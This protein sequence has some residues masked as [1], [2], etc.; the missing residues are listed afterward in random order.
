MV[1]SLFFGLTMYPQGISMVVFK[2]KAKL[3]N[4]EVYIDAIYRLK[5][6]DRITVSNQNYKI[7]FFT[8]AKVFEMPPGMTAISYTEILGKMTKTVNK[9]F[10]AYIE[11]YHLI[12]EINNNANSGVV[13]GIEGLNNKKK[14]ALRELDQYALPQD[15]VRT[16]K[17]T[18]LLEWKL[19]TAVSQASLR[20]TNQATGSVVLEKKIGATGSESIATPTEGWYSWEIVSPLENKSLVENAW[21]RM[22]AAEAQ[23]EKTEFAGFKTSIRVFDPETQELLIEDYLDTHQLDID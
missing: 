23:K 17:S 12:N 1:F 11:K 6:K 14:A 8:K 7:L 20:V 16:D 13:A 5:D 19:G 10:I 2:G 9:N 21:Q 4:I 22:P 3:N 18:M 15:S